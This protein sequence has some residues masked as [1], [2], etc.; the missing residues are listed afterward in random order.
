MLDSEGPRV[1]YAATLGTW[2]SLSTVEQTFN[3]GKAVATSALGC[4]HKPKLVLLVSACDTHNIYGC[5]R[6]ID[7]YD[8]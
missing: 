7:L 6:G 3:F 4:F 2:K 8:V 1:F 5:I